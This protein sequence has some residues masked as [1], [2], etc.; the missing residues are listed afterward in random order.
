MKKFTKMIALILSLTLLICFPIGV[1]AAEPEDTGVDTAAKGSLTIYKVDLTNAKKDGAWDSSYV[2]T[3]VYDQN[4][5][6]TLNSYA[7]KDVEF[8][9]L[10]VADVVQLTGSA[11]DGADSDHVETL[12]GISKTAGADLLNALGLGNGANRYE[13]ADGSDQLDDSKYYYQSDVLIS[14]LST[15]LKANATTVK[16]A[17]E[18]YVTESGTAMPLT[19]TYGK[20]K[21]ENLELGLYLVV[22]TKVPEMVTSTCNPFFICLPMTS[23]GG[24]WIYDVTVYPKNLTGNP[25]LDKT[26]RESKDDTG[27]H[28]GTNDITDGYA[29]TGT[30]SDG[31]VVDYQIVSTLPSITSASTYLTCYTFADT[32]SRG[33]TYNKHDVVLEFFTDAACTDPVARW[34]ETDGK[35]TVTYSS[36]DTGESGMTIEMTADG[37]KEMNTAVYSDASMV[38]SGY[39]DCTLRITY[40]AT[41]NSSADVVYGDNGNPNERAFTYGLELT[42][43]FS[44]GKGDFSKVQFIMQN[45]TDG[46]YV[47]AKLDEATGVYYVTSHVTDKKDATRFVPTAKDGKG[48]I[49]IKGLE[50]DEY[51]VTEIKTADGYTLLK[52]GIAVVISRKD[53]SASAT[54]DG[55]QAA[56]LADNGSA[57]ALVSLS[58][59]NTS[60]FDLPATGDRGVWMYGLA[61]ILLMTASAACIIIARKKFK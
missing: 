26:L 30:A 53:A 8:T 56:M 18:A 32:L 33:I 24:S 13:K 29:H 22:E 42:K 55:K 1:S 31:D 7:L 52:K 60:G 51:T 58:V 46:Y 41:V 38:N 40:A 17:L 5:N 15:A 19:D 39:S 11:A 57:N 3:G 25:T 14:A 48:K 20:T 37:L 47:K 35:F 34:A 6:D 4:V 59:V 54:V 27:K 49:L 45:K 44:D 10:R 36:T 2:S 23:S 28:N 61:G 50:D 9:Y 21:A 43:L 12:Y 16:N